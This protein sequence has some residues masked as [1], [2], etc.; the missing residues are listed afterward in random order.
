MVQIKNF[1]T[2][3]C[4]GT[5][6]VKTGEI[7]PFKIVKER[8]VASGVRRIEAV[9]GLAVQEYILQVPKL[10]KKEKV[11]KVEQEKEKIDIDALLKKTQTVHGVKVLAEKVAAENP[12]ELRDIADI[13][14]QKLGFGIIALGADIGGKAAL[15]VMVT[16][17]L[18]QKYSANDIIKE[19]SKEIGGTGG[20]RSDM[21][22]GGGPDVSKLA[23]VLAHFSQSLK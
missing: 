14:K 13:L 15:V 11:K 1:S 19:L 18:T 8:S 20:G 7:G 3:L 2:E 12:S 16:K 17:D 10:E 5:H 22:Q 4:G 9:S 21:A 6:L 23:E